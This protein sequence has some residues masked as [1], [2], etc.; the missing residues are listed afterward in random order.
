MSRNTRYKKLF[1]KT[2]LGE[3][4]KNFKEE[5]WMKHGGIF[6]RKD[7]KK[8]QTVLYVI[9]RLENIIVL[10]FLFINVY[11]NVVKE[12]RLCVG[13]VRNILKNLSIC[14]NVNDILNDIYVIIYQSNTICQKIVE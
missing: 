11:V 3:S 4:R 12:R 9:M 2:G 6:S 8:N 14:V 13:F 5:E 1:H 7:M 10:N